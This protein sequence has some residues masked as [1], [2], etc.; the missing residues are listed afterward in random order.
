MIG[1]QATLMAYID[2][3][4]VCAIFAAVLVPLVLVLVRPVRNRAAAHRSA[5]EPERA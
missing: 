4:V 1:N 5:A 2:V 3:F